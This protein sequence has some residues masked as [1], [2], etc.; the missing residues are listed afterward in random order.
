ML[1]VQAKIIL[2]LPHFCSEVCLHKNYEPLYMEDQPNDEE[3]E[4][5]VT[6]EVPPQLETCT[7]SY[8]NN[9]QEE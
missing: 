3:D 6:L 1:G 7:S 8:Y 5:L 4:S 9:F 2:C